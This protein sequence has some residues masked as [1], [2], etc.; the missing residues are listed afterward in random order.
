MINPAP[1]TNETIAEPGTEK[2]ENPP[3]PAL[4]DRTKNHTQRLRRI[5]GMARAL[6][7]KSSLLTEDPA[8][9]QKGEGQDLVSNWRKHRVAQ[10][11][12]KR[13]PPPQ[14]HRPPSPPTRRGRASTAKS[15]FRRTRTTTETADATKP[16]HHPTRTSDQRKPTNV[17]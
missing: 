4:S 17:W 9:I 6:S 5:G 7:C 14:Q 10:P 3:H 1:M 16:H 11:P 2:S 13:E 12:T 15:T 8:T